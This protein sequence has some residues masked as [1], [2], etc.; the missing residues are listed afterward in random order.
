MN[1]YVIQ[2]AISFPVLLSD[3]K[4]QINIIEDDDDVFIDHLP[5]PHPPSLGETGGTQA[6][7]AR[8]ALPVALPDSSFA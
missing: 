7:P 4:K 2:E 8:V 5:L 1:K 6:G 3:A